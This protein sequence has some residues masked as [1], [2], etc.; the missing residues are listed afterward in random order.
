MSRSRYNHR[1]VAPVRDDPNAPEAETAPMQGGRPAAAP[2]DPALPRGAAVGRF[3]VLDRIGQG[4]MGTVYAA[5]DPQLSRR[6]ALKVLGRDSDELERARIC[7]R[8]APWRS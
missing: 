5:W 6:V 4:G 3:V 7:A 1:S 8:R 2:L